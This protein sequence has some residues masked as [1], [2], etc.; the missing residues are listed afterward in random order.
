MGPHTSW[1]GGWRG[2]TETL[3]NVA[4]IAIGVVFLI[5]AVFN[6]VYTLSHTD[7]FYG[8]F[9]E[10]AWFG[11]ARWF[12]NHVVLPNGTAFTIF[13]I[14]FQATVAI[15]IFTRGDLATV[16]LFAG[17]GFALLAAF[18]SNIGG[19]IGNLSLAA[20]QFFLAFARIR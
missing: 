4:E 11:P 1:V 18:A 10:S 15:L 17:A 9:A 14:L 8:S 20:I 16:A 12:V 6:T 7:E 2:A 5:G 3:R 13:V 19:T